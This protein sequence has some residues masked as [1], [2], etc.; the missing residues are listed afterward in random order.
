MTQETPQNIQKENY[1]KVI[2]IWKFILLSVITFGIY[3]L[4]WFY[5]N[6]KFLKSEQNLKIT[7]LLRTIF[8]SIFA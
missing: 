4:V 3:E 8:A 5:R 1:S 6:W 2:P 7:P